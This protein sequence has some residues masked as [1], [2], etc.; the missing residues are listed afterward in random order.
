MSILTRPSYQSLLKDES[1][2]FKVACFFQIMILLLICFVLEPFPIV[3]ACHVL[4]SFLTCN[5]LDVLYLVL[6][7]VSKSVNLYVWLMH[8]FLSLCFLGFFIRLS[9]FLMSWILF[10]F[11]SPFSS[12]MMNLC[13]FFY[14]CK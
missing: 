6:P 8:L 7:L 13:C 12:P 14:T 4:T 5:G 2:L 1:S 9:I 10:L 3:L 11:L